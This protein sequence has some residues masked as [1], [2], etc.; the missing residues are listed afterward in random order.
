MSLRSEIHQQPAVLRGLLDSG[1]AD[2]ER[3]AAAIRAREIDYI[4]LAAR[5]TS[6][7]AGIYGQYV[8]G[9][10]NGLPVALAAPSLFTIYKRPPRLSRALVVGVSQ[11]GQSPDI[12][13][14]LDEANRQGALTMSVTNDPSSPLAQAATISL[15]IRAGTE[16]A[17]AA[18]KTYSAQLL[19]FAMLAAALAGDA[20]RRAE[21]EAVPE[22]V[23]AALQIEGAIAKAA[24]EFSQMSHCVV[25]GRGYHFA[26]ALEW[27]LK[28]KEL[29]YVVA[30]R[31]STAE[32]QHGPIAL[33]E[34]GF[35]V[36]AVAPRDAGSDDI[37]A[38]L[39]RLTTEHGAQVL[40]ISDDDDILATAGMGLRLPGGLPS[41][42]APIISIAPAQL[43]CHHLALARGFDPDAPRGLSK[44]TRTR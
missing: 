24:A 27:S 13:G 9:A 17:V 7:H 2:I 35:P 38:L 8:L 10:F 25:L 5:G 44:V 6:E 1:W 4:Y 23:G 40:A 29:T 41:W 26:T 12:V 32:F 3:A 28:L 30:E 15:D 43:F 36:L 20:S 19:T 18:T 31:Y 42:L 14:V 34:P 16:R 33:V 22:A 11:S 37:R 21:L 39:S